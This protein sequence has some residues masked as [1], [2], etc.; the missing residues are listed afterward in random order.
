[1]TKSAFPSFSL[2]AHDGKTYTNTDFEGQKVVFYFYPKDDTSGCTLEAKDFRDHAD[3]FKK[4]GVAIVG[5]SPDSEKSHCK[6]IEKHELNFL[7]L[8]DEEKKLLNALGIW[9][10][11]SMY[12][13]KYMGVER[14]TYLVDENG[15]ILKT[16]NKVNPKGHVQEVLEFAKSL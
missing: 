4:L 8:C 15:N 7:L 3:D 5:V 12:G 10:E 2:L 16:W 1:M 9:K 11:K 14:T 13:R 6:F